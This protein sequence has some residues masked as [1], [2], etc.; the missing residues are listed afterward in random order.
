MTTFLLLLVTG[1]SCG[2]DPEAWNKIV[3]SAQSGMYISGT[4]TIYSE[5]TL[6]SAN[7]LSAAAIDGTLADGTTADIASIYTWLKADGQFNII[8]VDDSGSQVSYG[9]GDVVTSSAAT[10]GYETN[11]LSE[12][13]SAFTVS[14]DGLY[15]VLINK[16]DNQ[17]TI[18]PVAFGIIGDATP[19]AWNSETS[20]GAP[21]YDS[22][23]YYVTFTLT[24]TTLDKKQLKFRYGGIWGV[25]VP[26]GD[27]TVTVHTNMGLTAD[28]GN[29][30]EAYSE[31]KGGG[32][33]FSVDKKGTWNV[34]IRL[35]LKSKVFS[36][37][38]ICTGEDTST[39]EL[40]TSMFMIGSPYSWDWANSYQMTPVNGVDGAFWAIQYMPSDAQIKF[41]STMAW[42]GNDF[43]AT[44]EDKLGLGE[45]NSGSSNIN[46]SATGYYLFIVKASL[47]N[48]KQSVVKKFV[49]A[50]PDVYLM[51]SVIGGWDANV[52]A[53]KFTIENNVL[54]SPAFT[55]PGELRMYVNLNDYITGWE[56]W[57]SEFIII[58][59]K[60]NFRGNGGDQAR[61]NVT[62][63]QKAK[64]NFVDGT[65]V[66]E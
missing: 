55:A 56:W 29:L 43:G 14:S 51:G 31:C 27:A 5:G 3:T 66:I 45:Y 23:Q 63:G 13:G 44:S 34:T 65:G 37:S 53:N 24:G 61:L 48:D 10:I 62:A 1:T 17:I 64:L 26:Y 28:S 18:V 36:A 52:A 19:D 6:A 35:S 54:V 15:M 39:A 30:T 11:K 16:K 49:I 46:F 21:T 20:M 60:I 41:S 22:E 42:D 38:G 57:K 7:I 59:G 47:S 50:S 32:A 4:A 9:K 12:S 25:A 2:E 33:N 58:D 8:K 40:P